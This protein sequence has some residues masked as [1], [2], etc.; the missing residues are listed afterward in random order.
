M[1]SMS[2]SAA[3]ALLIVIAVPSAALAVGGPV[4]PLQGNAIGAPGGSSSYGAFGAGGA[5]IVKRLGAGWVPTGAQ[6]RV[7]GRY[8]IPGVDYGGSTTG[9]SAN[10]R[11]LI[12]AGMTRNGAAPRLTRLLVVNAPR[13]TIR[14][15][16]TLPGWWTVDAISPEGRW[17][18]LI[19][20]RS[21]NIS[22]YEVRAYDLL[23]R[24][25]LIKPIVDPDDRGKAMTGFPLTR[26]MSAASRWAYTLYMRPSGAPFIH[27]LDTVGRRAV[28]IDLPSLTG[29]DLGNGHLRLTAGGALLHVD[30][31]GVTRALIDT[32]MLAIITRVA[33]P[34]RSASSS[35]RTRPVA[36]MSAPRRSGGVPW[37]L[38]AGLIAALAVLAV[39]VARRMRPGRRPRSRTS[40]APP[41]AP[42]AEP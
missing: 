28:C 1:Q 8:G 22:K 26:V 5:T 15:R 16:I 35:V 19:H 25:M 13:L 6:L 14:A 2:R 38:F 41:P 32:R 10:G 39:G 17:L 27:A 40:T 37:E 24:R 31:A 11:T 21:S 7:L 29:I 36:H 33:T 12:L 30:V 42:S 9:L 18:Y 4:P 23:R 3:L 34:S 20:Y